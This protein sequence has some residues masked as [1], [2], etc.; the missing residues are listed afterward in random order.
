MFLEFI[1]TVRH[2]SLSKLI[3]KDGGA[4][5]V[6]FQCERLATVGQVANHF[7]PRRGE[8]TCCTF[9][10]G[11]SLGPGASLGPKFNLAHLIGLEGALGGQKAERSIQRLTGS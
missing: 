7:F 3:E 4:L 8:R 2:L 1:A 9:P 11:E 5:N 6:S 10:S